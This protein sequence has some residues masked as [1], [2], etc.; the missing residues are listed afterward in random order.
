M[1]TYHTI[2]FE[3]GGVKGYAYPD[4]LNELE[5][6]KIIDLKKINTFVGSSAGA[7]TAAL[8]ACGASPA[9][10][11]YY[12]E[13]DFNIFKDDKI[14]Y[15][16]DAWNIYKHYGLCE[17]K[18][19]IKWFKECLV[20][21]LWGKTNQTII[22][23][24]NIT[25]GDLYKYNDKT[26]IVTA[27]N[28]STGKLQIFSPKIT[29]KTP[30]WLAVRA[31]MAIPL[32]FR[33]VMWHGDRL[34]DGGLLANLFDPPGDGGELALNLV[35]NKDYGKNRR[36]I[37]SIFS[38][39]GSLIDVLMYRSETQHVSD[40]LRNNTINID[41]GDIKATDFDLSKRQKQQLA[42]AGKE[43][44]LRFIEKRNNG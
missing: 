42:N 14:G 37:T 12:L 41:T 5:K 4:A 20:D 15:F 24:K 18:T 3:G 40:S 35:S 25:F 38:L 29:P 19:F 22:D 23:T 31:S 26:L 44:V 17:G 9:Q 33:P 1:Q 43:G 30:I 11:K 21:L 10:I 2:I 32:F 6:H 16:R 28:L 8:L 36:K 7:I 13:V 34:V 27:S 39:I